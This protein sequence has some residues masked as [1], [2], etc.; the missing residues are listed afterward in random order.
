MK[1][2]ERL[3]TVFKFFLVNTILLT[4]IYNVYDWQGRYFIWGVLEV[5]GPN[6][7]LLVIAALGVIIFK[8]LFGEIFRLTI[9]L[10]FLNEVS[11]AIYEKH[12]IVF[13]L[14]T[15]S[16]SENIIAIDNSYSV[17][18]SV[19]GFL[20]AIAIYLFHRYSRIEKINY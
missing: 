12:L 6:F 18:I 4:L 10:A 9:F 20:S 16:T 1:I 13:G 2:E 15:P 19:S 3:K 14:F 5:L 8:A 11:F 7:L 17:F